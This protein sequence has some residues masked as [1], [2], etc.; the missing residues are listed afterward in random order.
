MLRLSNFVFRVLLTGLAALCGGSDM[1]AQQTST[2]TT[3]GDWLQMPADGRPWKHPG[4]DL[5]FPSQLGD[6]ELKAGF[7]DKRAADGVALTYAHKTNDLKA[8]IVIFPCGAEIRNVPDVQAVT[9]LHSEKLADDFVSLAKDRGYSQKQR[10]AITDQP[11][12]LWSRGVIPMSSLTLDL[13]PAD[14]SREAELPP[15]NQ[16]LGLLIY[17][18]HFIQLSVVMPSSEIPK[19]R[20]EAD[21]LITLIL[22]CI[23]FP[24]LN[25]TLIKLCTTYISKP[26]TDEARQAADSLLSMSKES[27]VFEVAFPGEAL[28]PLL[29]EI[30]ARSPELALDLLRG[31]VVGSGL[32]ILR[33]GTVDQSLEEGARVMLTTWRMLKDQ[34]KPVNSAFM[35]E[36]AR[37]SEA[38]NAAAF[39]K[40]RMRN[41]PPSQ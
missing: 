28:T 12:P 17:Q 21:E 18:D 15:I 30:N 25:S 31:F 32:S 6:F 22:H 35:F 19:L 9:R 14:S 33:N 36:L 5:K 23:R 39:L 37:A 10:S 3:S 7:Q 11:V 34:G 29:D 8:D 38:R 26:L 1:Q 24:A 16:W 40:E 20:K 4:T 27:P 13:S 41:A 2:S